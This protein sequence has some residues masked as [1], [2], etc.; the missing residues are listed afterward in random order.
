MVV[1]GISINFLWF[2]A[3]VGLNIHTAERQ[4]LRLKELQVNREST[5]AELME[6]SRGSGVLGR[7]RLETALRAAKGAGVAA[8]RLL[9]A[10]GRLAELRSHERRCDTLAG[11]VQRALPGLEKQPWRYEELLK[12]AE[13]LRPWTK[14]LER[15]V[16]QGKERGR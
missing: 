8:E 6:A 12:A 13:R 5:Q 3:R 2:D 16:A 4:V 9:L 1:G 14:R 15:L 7:Q 10:S 11:E